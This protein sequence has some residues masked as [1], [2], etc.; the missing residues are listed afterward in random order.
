M[1]LLPA[2]LC[3]AEE[4]KVGTN[5]LACGFGGIPALAQI[6][7]PSLNLGLRRTPI[8]PSSS[9]GAT[10]RCRHWDFVPRWH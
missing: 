7:S 4:D 5:E 6:D 9:G 3:L 10:Q 2:A 1:L 8:S